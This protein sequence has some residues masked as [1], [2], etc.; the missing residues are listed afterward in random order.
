MLKPLKEF[1]VSVEDAGSLTHHLDCGVDRL[2][3]GLRRLGDFGERTLVVISRHFVKSVADYA[4]DGGDSAHISRETVRNELGWHL[5]TDALEGVI[6]ANVHAAVPTQKMGVAH[7]LMYA[8]FQAAG[9]TIDCVPAT[10]QSVVENHPVNLEDA[11]FRKRLNEWFGTQEA[12]DFAWGYEPAIEA[13]VEN[14]KE[15]EAGQIW[16]LEKVGVDEVTREVS[17]KI[18]AKAVE[19]E[20][21]CVMTHLDDWKRSHCGQTWLRE[22]LDDDVKEDVVQE[23]VDNWDHGIESHFENHLE[24]WKCDE[25]EDYAR[26]MVSEDPGEY[27]DIVFEH[28]PDS[29][30]FKALGESMGWC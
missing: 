1:L 20:W 28:V 18:I 10:V 6:R 12:R 21:G 2:C 13:H 22:G 17:E 25:G 7:S 14:F 9:S 5:S 4:N 26:E 29:Q 15:S 3:Q 23:A 11:A 30:I 27:K 16:R 8:V 24:A 19:E